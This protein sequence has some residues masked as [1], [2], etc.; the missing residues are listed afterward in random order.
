VLQPP[1]PPQ[2][3]FPL[4]TEPEDQVLLEGCMNRYGLSESQ[5]STLQNHC[6]KRGVAYIREKMI[7]VDQEPRQNVTKAFL[8][9]LRD[10]WK[11]KIQTVK[12]ASPPKKKRVEPKPQEPEVTDEERAQTSAKLREFIQTLRASTSP[13]AD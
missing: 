6:A 9:A 2:L 7:V 3:E 4:E 13:S 8:A 5:R 12:P 1:S 11:P 10:D